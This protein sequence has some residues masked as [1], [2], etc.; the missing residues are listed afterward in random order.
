MLNDQ[1]TFAAEPASIAKARGFVGTGL[2][3][4]GCEPETVEWARVL[5]SDLATR[6]VR[7]TRGEFAVSV[8]Q[9]GPTVTIELTGLDDIEQAT[10]QPLVGELLRGWRTHETPEGRA[11]AFDVSLSG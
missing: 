7:G 10:G 8:R 9:R 5:V 3:K 11:V 2:T 1:A 4:A 6:A